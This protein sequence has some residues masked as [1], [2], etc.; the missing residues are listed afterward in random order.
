M[1]AARE[2]AHDL[3]DKVEDERAG[4]ATLQEAATKLKLPYRV[5][6]AVSADLKAPDGNRCRRHPGSAAASSA[7]PSRATSAWRTARSA[8][9]GETWVFFDVLEIIPARDRTLDE[10]RDRGR[11]GVDGGR[12][13]EAASAHWRIRS[14]PG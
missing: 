13:G 14:S 7:K 6:E 5:V 1:R 8:A 11:C 12:D 4:G 3:Y 10:V 9:T 2:S